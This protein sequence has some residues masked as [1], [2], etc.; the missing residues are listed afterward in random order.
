[1]TN[2]NASR[3]I[4]M[5]MSTNHFSFE[6]K[7]TRTREE[8]KKNLNLNLNY[9]EFGLPCVVTVLFQTNVNSNLLALSPTGSEP[10]IIN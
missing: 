6:E 1:M 5:K 8:L 7:K 9:I 2:T 3:E 4:N 10:L